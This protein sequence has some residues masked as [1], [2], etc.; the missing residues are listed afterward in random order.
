[1]KTLYYLLGVALVVGFVLCYSLNMRCYAEETTYL[2]EIILYNSVRDMKEDKLLSDGEIVRTLGY[3]DRN[4]FGAATY[5]IRKEKPPSYSERLSNGYY[6]EIVYGEY[7]TPEMFG[8]HGDGVSDDQPYI[9]KAILSKQPVVLQKTYIVG[10]PVEIDTTYTFDGN[11]RIIKAAD[12]F[13]GNCVIHIVGAT[14]TRMTFARNL[15]VDCAGKNIDGIFLDNKR[16]T[17]E[18]SV[19]RFCG[20]SA[21]RLENSGGSHILNCSASN[22]GRLYEGSLFKDSI[23]MKND[24]A[25]IYV[26]HFDYIDFHSGIEHR[27]SIGF[28]NNVHGFVLRYLDDIWQNSSFFKTVSESTNYAVTIQNSYPDSQQ[29]CYDIQGNGAINIIGGATYINADVWNES[30]RSNSNTFILRHKG[31]AEVNFIGVSIKGA[32]ENYDPILFSTGDD[33]LNVNLINCHFYNVLNNIHAEDL[34]VSEID[35][36]IFETAQLIRVNANTQKINIKLIIKEPSEIYKN[37]DTDN[38]NFLCI[39]KKPTLATRALKSENKS[40]YHILNAICVARCSDPPNVFP[41]FAY[42]SDETIYLSF[43]E[44]INELSD[45]EYEVFIEGYI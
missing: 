8:A 25:D 17:L 28:Y 44:M 42:C 26:D 5:V 39:A 32:S 22:N 27:R 6:A 33:F 19:V 30:I 14:S 38:M 37:N 18:N 41:I 2:P 21:Y 36:I 13:E 10:V 23:A 31:N 24:S 34:T 35:G 29:Y 3:Y 45:E 11:N 4:D 43:N 9:E 16:I 7:V 12:N 15:V 20:G 1:M 40:S